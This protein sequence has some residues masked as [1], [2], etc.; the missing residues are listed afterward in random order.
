MFLKRSQ[1]PDLKLENLF[2]GSTV[3]IFGR[4]L[5]IVEYADFA[6]KE[7]LT[8]AKEHTFALLRPEAFHRIGQLL[9]N[10]P[11]NEFVVA[12]LKTIALTPLDAKI[13]FDCSACSTDPA[14]SSSPL[15]SASPSFEQYCESAC[16]GN[17]VAMELVGPRGVSLLRTLAGDPDFKVA[18]SKKPDSIVASCGV[19]Q[20][21]NGFYC[22]PTLEKAVQD[23]AFMFDSPRPS[24]ALL[25][26]C[27][28]SLV[29]P[30]A[31]VD[32]MPSTFL[33]LSSSFLPSA[34]LCPSNRQPRTHS[35]HNPCNRLHHQLR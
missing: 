13:L 9:A 21:H 7:A 10:L 12:K 33:L 27:T 30:H 18:K 5:K 34:L 8:K 19:D 29:F 28:V 1:Y 31:I 35:R 23:S 20:I 22:A 11:K 17:S 3:V 26:D 6:T 24:T 2:V 14:A 4:Q 16:E 25:A 15:H 32:G